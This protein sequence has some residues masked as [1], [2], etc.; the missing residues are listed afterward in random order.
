MTGVTIRH[1]WG[2][3]IEQRHTATTWRRVRVT[4]TTTGVSLRVSLS[5]SLTE[6]CE[7][8]GPSQKFCGSLSLSLTESCE[9]KGP[10]S[11][12][13]TES[14]ALWAGTDLTTT[15]KQHGMHMHMLMCAYCIL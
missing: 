11:V 2:L 1:A 9:D 10:C 3:T 8:E 13:V 6:S 7:D 12:S 4:A 14:C 5:L 15:Y